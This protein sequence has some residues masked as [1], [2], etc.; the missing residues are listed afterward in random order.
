MGS[1]PS[2]AVSLLGGNGSHVCTYSIPNPS[3]ASSSGGAYYG[4]DG[5]P[6]DW[7]GRR[8]RMA[9]CSGWG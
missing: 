8:C 9:I 5:T 3:F 6:F 7:Y 1:R 4:T 2:D